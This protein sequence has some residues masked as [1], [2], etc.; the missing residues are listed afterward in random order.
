MG[1]ELQAIAT[2]VREAAQAR[3]VGGTTAAE[4]HRYNAAGRG[5]ARRLLEAI[6]PRFLRHP[7]HGTLHE[8]TLNAQHTLANLLVNDDEVADR[9]DPPEVELAEAR[10]LYETVIAGL[11]TPYTTLHYTTLHYTALHCTALRQRSS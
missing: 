6:I 3:Y 9:R 11:S 7:D 2:Q 5:E 10:R 4:L 8:I 1:R